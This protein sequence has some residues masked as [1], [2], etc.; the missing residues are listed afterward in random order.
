M[1]IFDAVNAEAARPKD[2]REVKPARVVSVQITERH[3][4]PAGFLPNEV[5]EVKCWCP[6]CPGLLAQGDPPRLPMGFREVRDGTGHPYAPRRYAL[7]EGAQRRL[8]ATGTPDRPREAGWKRGP[9]TQTFEL[10]GEVEIRCPL[11][12]RWSSVRG[13][14]P[15]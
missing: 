12:D 14:D 4:S 9:V 5:R 3:R 8:A 15:V 13:R 11:C 7:T 6:T 10:E 1:S 2:T